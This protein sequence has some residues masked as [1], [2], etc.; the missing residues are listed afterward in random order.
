MIR[1]R[2]VFVLFAVTVV[3]QPGVFMAM[4]PASIRSARGVHGRGY[5]RLVVDLA[6][7][8]FTP[9]RL[10]LGETGAQE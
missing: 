6:I 4:L 9:D 2:A 8:H 5:G 3:G 7:T 10:E 1:A